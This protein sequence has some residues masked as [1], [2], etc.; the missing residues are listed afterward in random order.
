[1]P[2]VEEV[3]LPP[4]EEPPVAETKAKKGSAKPRPRRVDPD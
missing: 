4:K 1:M 2:P 3:G